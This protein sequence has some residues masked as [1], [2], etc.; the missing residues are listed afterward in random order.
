MKPIRFLYQDES[1]DVGR[2][3]PHFVV[4]LLMVR[5]REPL[6]AAVRRARDRWHYA[7][8]LHFEKMSNLRM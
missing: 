5:E 7:N 4:G 1:G 8:E 6:W 2:G 3:Q